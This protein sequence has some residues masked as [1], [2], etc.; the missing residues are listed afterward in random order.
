MFWK[1]RAST[2]SRNSSPPLKSICQ[3]LRN[4]NSCTIV[5]TGACW[6]LAHIHSMGCSCLSYLW[7]AGWGASIHIL[8]EYPFTQTSIHRMIYQMIIY[9]GGYVIQ[10]L[11]LCSCSLLRPQ[12]QNPVL[13]HQ[14]L[15][16]VSTGGHYD[17]IFPLNYL[18]DYK[19]QKTKDKKK[20]TITSKCDP[21]QREYGQTKDGNSRC[22]NGQVRYS[23]ARLNPYTGAPPA[24]SRTV[25]VKYPVRGLVFGFLMLRHV[26]VRLYYN[27][28]PPR[29]SLL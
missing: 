23:L 26:G 14:T 6:W 29:V 27:P 13:P 4:L 15:Y 22:R 3:R 11:W 2:P 24:T 19:S 12:V 17:V 25:N 10:E 20:K 1:W 28:D 8:H 18:F 7:H 21:N 16:L 5:L 9:E